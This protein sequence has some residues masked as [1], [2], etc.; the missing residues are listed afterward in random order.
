[1]GSRTGLGSCTSRVSRLRAVQ[2][3]AFRKGLRAA[4]RRDRG[5]VSFGRKEESWPGLIPARFQP[6]SPRTGSPQPRSPP[7]GPGVS[8]VSADPQRA[9]LAAPSLGAGRRRV[10]RRGSPVGGAHTRAGGKRGV[11]RPGLD[12]GGGR[13]RGW[14]SA[15]GRRCALGA[16]WRG[17]LWP[18]VR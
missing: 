9:G 10:R 16:E 3:E 12:A 5:K 18:S 17:R 1:M 14:R 2:A 4:S 15:A 13:S 8:Q 7:T 6:R 11:A